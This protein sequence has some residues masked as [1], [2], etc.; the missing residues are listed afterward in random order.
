MLRDGDGNGN[1]ANAGIFNKLAQTNIAT[2]LPRYPYILQAKFYALLLTMEHKKSLTMDTFSFIDNLN[3]IHLLLNYLKKPLCTI[4]PPQQTPHYQY[5]K[6]FKQLV[7][8]HHHLQ[9]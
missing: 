6:Y 7:P 5:N 1:I 8:Y 3:S 4:Q 2:R 9:S